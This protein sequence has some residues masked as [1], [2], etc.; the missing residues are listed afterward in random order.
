MKRTAGYLLGFLGVGLGLPAA[1]GGGAAAPAV[2]GDPVGAVVISVA[3]RRPRTTTW[4]VNYWNWMPTYGDDVSGTETPI[5]ALKTSVLRVGGYNNDANT[6]DR[7]DPA[8]L[9]R[10]VAYARA[11]GAEPLLQASVRWR[12]VPT[13]VATRTRWRIQGEAA[14]RAATRFVT[15]RCRWLLLSPRATQGTQDR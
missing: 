15:L 4:S 8:A 9:D 5:A 7:F 12:S 6:A 13:S 11:V 10:A 2:G 1:C 14:A 3:A